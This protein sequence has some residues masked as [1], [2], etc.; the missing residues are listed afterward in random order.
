MVKRDYLSFVWRLFWFLCI[1]L[2]KLGIMFLFCFTNPACWRAC[3]IGHICFCKLPLKFCFFLSRFVCESTLL[4]FALL[5][6]HLTLSSVVC[7][8]R[9][10]WK[11]LRFA[12]RKSGLKKII[13]TFP[14]S[15]PPP[16][17]PVNVT[18]RADKRDFWSLKFG[19]GVDLGGAYGTSEV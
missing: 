16:H 9:L 19:V 17:A 1:N 10:I 14:I 5:Q 3:G 15:P 4:C 11:G 13:R 2:T 7:R 12:Y 8:K 6:L 18:L